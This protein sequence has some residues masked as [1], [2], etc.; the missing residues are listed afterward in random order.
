MKKYIYCE[1][2]RLIEPHN[3]MYSEY[4]GKN[5]INLYEENRNKLIKFYKKQIPKKKNKL[6]YNDLKVLQKLLDIAKVY[7]SNSKKQ[8]QIKKLQ[9]QFMLLDNDSFVESEVL[10]Y[11]KNNFD[12]KKELYKLIINFNFNNFLEKDKLVL[13]RIL[14]KFEIS[15]KLY[16]SY[17]L[18]FTEPTGSFDNLK[19]YWLVLN[20]LLIYYMRDQDLQYLNAI[21]KISDTLCSQ[22]K[23]DLA[24]EFIS[25]S[26]AVPL[27]IETMIIDNL[28]SYR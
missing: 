9:K 5:L 25:N 19:I 11:D 1:K 18:D 27:I 16:Q 2:N 20:A 12:T 6:K 21:L 8:L 24:N 3:Y 28:K 23:Y 4:I 15:K 14:K 10:N 22:D 13:N 7:F 17:K 26:H